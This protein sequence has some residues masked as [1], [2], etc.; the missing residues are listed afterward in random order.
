MS[1]IISPWSSYAAAV[2]DVQCEPFAQE[3]MVIAALTVRGQ[4]TREMT[5]NSLIKPFPRMGAPGI[6][7]GTSRV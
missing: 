2:G 1:A 6:E 4:P 3:G 5:R 7:P